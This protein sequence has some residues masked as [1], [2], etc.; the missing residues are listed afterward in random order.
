MTGDSDDEKEFR[1][2]LRTTPDRGQASWLPLPGIASIAAMA[3]V[4]N[5]TDWPSE[6]VGG[7]A[8]VAGGV[9]VLLL[10]K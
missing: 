4:Y 1:R 9:T 6:A 3:L 5:F 7:A 8:L 10:R 2:A